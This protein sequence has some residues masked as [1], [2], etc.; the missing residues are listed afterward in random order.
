MFP[1]EKEP[2]N[3]SLY[4][5]YRLP[6]PVARVAQYVGLDLDAFDEKTYKSK[7]IAK[8]RFIKYRNLN[9]QIKAIAQIIKRLE[10]SDVGILLPQNDGV[11]R[12]SEL[13][14]SNGVN[15]EAKY[16]DSSDWHNSVDNLDFSTSNPKV[17][18]FHSAKGLQFETVFLLG[19]N[20]LS[21]NTPQKISSQKALYVAM[22]RTYR[23][24][25][26]MYS[27]TLPSPLKEVPNNLYLTTETDTVEDI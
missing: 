24:L 8:P 26:I 16:T 22:T 2:K 12:V 23:Y 18:T 20:S 15:N 10:L 14:N 17:M 1:Y 4:R 7:E 3:F 19:V 5:N 27:D 9:E 13:L 11:C 21:D 6:L 25:Y